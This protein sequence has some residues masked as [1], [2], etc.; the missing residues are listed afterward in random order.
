MLIRFHKGGQRFAHASFRFDTLW[1]CFQGPFYS[2]V[3]ASVVLTFLFPLPDDNEHKLLDPI[4]VS[5]PSTILFHSI[6]HGL[7]NLVVSYFRVF[8]RTIITRLSRNVSFA[9]VS[10]KWLL[11]GSLGIFWSPFVFFEFIYFKSVVFT[12]SHLK[13]FKNCPLNFQ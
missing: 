8:F 10:G 2:I 6:R 12:L 1:T 7:W 4:F 9:T 5:L 3:R 13:T 11:S